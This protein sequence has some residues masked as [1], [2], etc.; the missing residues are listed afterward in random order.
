MNGI[1]TGKV[2]I[3]SAYFGQKRRLNDEELKMQ[4]V[5]LA[6][7]PGNAA[8]RA[9]VLGLSPQAYQHIGQQE[10]TQ[11]RPFKRFRDFLSR[12]VRVFA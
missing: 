1:N 11:H 4:S 12:F 10:K 5:L 6:E 3:G 9:A 7:M 8:N 2:I